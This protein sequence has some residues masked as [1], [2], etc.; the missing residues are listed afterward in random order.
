MN[1]TH[2]SKIRSRS[3][4]LVLV[5]AGMI[6]TS[7]CGCE[8]LLLLLGGTPPKS[9][10][11]SLLVALEVK[12]VAVEDNFFERIGVDFDFDIN[13]EPDGESFGANSLLENTA[14]T[15]AQYTGGEDGT[16]TVV[17]KNVGM[18]Q[19]LPIAVPV[20]ESAA[21]FVK[22]FPALRANSDFGFDLDPNG[23]M[24]LTGLDGL[25]PGMVTKN[26]ITPT[27]ASFQAA[28]LDDIQ[29]NLLLAQIATE[30]NADVVAEPRIT[31]FDS[32]RSI[33][34][35]RNEPSA[36]NDVESDIADAAK[37]V[38]PNVSI[39]Q[40]GIVLDV[41]P[42]VSADRRF[43]Q[44]HLVPGT[45]GVIVPTLSPVQI[46]GED[47]FLETPVIQLSMIQTMV[48]IP[49]GMTVLIGG[50]KATSD[51]DTDDQ[52]PVLRNLPYINRLFAN[53][54]PVKETQSL[55]IMVTPRIIIEE[56]Q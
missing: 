15:M 31:L 30:M 2:T 5:F 52:L 50:M 25:S 22:V 4:G 34:V 41:R 24:G 37:M 28:L 44:L 33:I 43:V 18:N 32:Q 9:S 49:D 20:S 13:G 19:F 21:D 51:G 17:P 26:A 45:R 40:S 36:I 35:L 16:Y 12:F 38:D 11:Q 53:T 3:A 56:E 46:N 23:V 10:G 1:N 8:L 6:V 42:V 48:S 55:M 54:G 7:V 47:T 27:F 39:V 29:L 14:A